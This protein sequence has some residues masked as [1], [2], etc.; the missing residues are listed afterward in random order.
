MNGCVVANAHG[1]PYKMNALTL[2]LPEQSFNEFL[3]PEFENL[4]FWNIQEHKPNE[5]GKEFEIVFS[6][7][8]FFKYSEEDKTLFIYS[9]AHKDEIQFENII[10]LHDL[11]IKVFA[12][13]G[14]FVEFKTKQDEK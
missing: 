4:L 1:H 9:K 10:Y 11:Q 3:I 8:S 13:L 5:E 14:V 6:D 7:G 2:S 12:V